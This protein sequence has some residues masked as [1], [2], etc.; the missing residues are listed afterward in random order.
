M[1]GAA[2]GLEE[3]SEH[4]VPRERDAVNTNPM[5]RFC[6]TLTVQLGKALA[7]AKIAYS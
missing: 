5:A 3:L 4:V 1:L 2:A 7:F 6:W